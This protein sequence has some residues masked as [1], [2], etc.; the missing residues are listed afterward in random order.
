VER[1]LGLIRQA[2]LGG[3]VANRELEYTAYLM[4]TANAGQ[5]LDSLRPRPLVHISHRVRA[6]QL[7]G[8]I[9]S[10]ETI[11]F[12]TRIFTQ[13]QDPVVR[14]AAAE[15]IGAI[16]M[17][18]DGIA[19]N[20]FSNAARSVILR[21]EQVLAAMASATGAICRFS[22]PPVMETGIR[23]LTSLSTGNR[24]QLVQTIA[25]RELETLGK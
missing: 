17:D 8:I 10:R 11:P 13:D 20:A 22:G 6:L 18:P 15:A 3:R 19:L 5:D 24:P 25:K 23:I 14:A 1:E 7:L 12:L 9:G 2:I 21:E 16:G 4:E